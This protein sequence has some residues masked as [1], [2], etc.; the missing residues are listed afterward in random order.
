MQRRRAAIAYNVYRSTSSGFLPSLA[1]RIAS[2]ITGT[3]FTDSSALVTGTPYYYIVRAVDTG[4]G[5]EDT[6]L[7][8][9]PGTVTASSTAVSQNFA[10]G[11]P[12]AGWTLVNGGTGTQ[13][14]TTANPFPRAIPSGMTA[15][16]EIIDSDFD[17]P[18]LTQDDHLVT[19][20]FDCSGAGTVTLE[21]D[22]Y[23]RHT[24][25]ARLCRR[26]LRRRYDL[27]EP[28]RAPPKVASR[29]R[30]P[31]FLHIT[32]LAAAS[33]TGTVRFRYTGTCGS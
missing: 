22:H 12:P 4:N 15:P 25:P 1:N 27:E 19:P 31:S 2:G 30:Q 21:F 17:G 11:D 23:F 8:R 28:P 26:L 7:V 13:R 20:S 5:A 6:N 29:P 24:P 9:V 16:I 18:G 3:S 32:P 10:S 33:P 14:W